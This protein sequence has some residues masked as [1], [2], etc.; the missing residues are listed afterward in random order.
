MFKKIPKILMFLV[1]AVFLS[2]GSANATWYGFD[3]DPLDSNAS[4]EEIELYMEGITPPPGDVSL[5]ETT[6]TSNL[7]KLFGGVEYFGDDMY[8]TSGS[9]TYIEITFAE[10]NITEIMF[11]WAGQGSSKE[12]GFFA[13]AKYGDQEYT[14]FFE[15]TFAFDGTNGSYEGQGTTDYIL[16]D[17]TIQS[18]K[19]TTSDSSGYVALDNLWIENCVAVVPEPATMLLLG[20]GL[21]ALAGLGRKKSRRNIS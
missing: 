11:D 8:L 18:L 20:S 14:K 7:Q 15:G 5:N 13:Y 2:A 3:Y 17:N 12:S 21:I 10:R 4:Y 1:F 19:F 16:F 6:T 9:G